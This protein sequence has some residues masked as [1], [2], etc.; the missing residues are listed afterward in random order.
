MITP[1]K[2]SFG[3]TLLTILLLFCLSPSP[4]R[5]RTSIDGQYW[6][7]FY[8]TIPFSEQWLGY[9]EVNPR[10]GDSLSEFDQ[11]LIR[12]ALGYQ[13]TP[14][15]SLWQGYAWVTNYRPEFRGEHRIFQQLIYSRKYSFLHM[16]NRWR[17]EERIIQ[18]GQGTGIRA[19]SMLR[20]NFPFDRFP[21]WA[22]AVYDEIFVN[23]TAVG[24]GPLAGF[25]QNRLF[26]GFNRTL[27]PNYNVDI[28]YQNQAINT[29]ADGLV[30]RINHI[31]LIQIFANL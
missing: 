16:M 28:G 29:R 13:V 10:V 21:L 27:T 6:V 7:P 9:F 14:R 30:N 2:K 25:D 20:A 4:A 17:L 5:A 8:L 31:L 1:Q 22:F 19:R 24:N 26:L 12:P 11:L 18:R 3:I 23:L 15:L